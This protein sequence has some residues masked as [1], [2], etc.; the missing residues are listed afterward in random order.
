MIIEW[1]KF[2]KHFLFFSVS[3]KSQILKKG[4]SR[5]N[6]PAYLPTYVEALEW[7]GG[8]GTQ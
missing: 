2:S 4:C 7:G 3:N 5:L 1:R 6:L 8:E